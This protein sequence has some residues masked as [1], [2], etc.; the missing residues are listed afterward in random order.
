VRQKVEGAG[1]VDVELGYKIVLVFKL[2]EIFRVRL[3]ALDV[4]PQRQVVLED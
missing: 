3:P 4:L 1:G 2:Y